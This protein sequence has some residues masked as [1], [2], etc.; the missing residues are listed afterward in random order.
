MPGILILVHLEMVTVG[1]IR[2]ASCGKKTELMQNSLWV[3]LAGSMSDEN[4]FI[5]YLLNTYYA[6]TT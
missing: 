5:N 3:G 1:K 6:Q 2:R 4:P